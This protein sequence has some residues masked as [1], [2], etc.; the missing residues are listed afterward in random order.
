MGVPLLLS[1]SSLIDRVKYSLSLWCDGTFHFV[2]QV[3]NDLQFELMSVVAKNF[4]SK[5]TYTM[6]R[7]L[8]AWKTITS[9]ELLF[10]MF[11]KHLLAKDLKYSFVCA[12]QKRITLISYFKTILKMA[13]AETLKGFFIQIHIWKFF[14]G[15]TSRRTASAVMCT[16]KILENV[17]C[18][19]KEQY[20]R[21]FSNRF[22][23]DVV[24]AEN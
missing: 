24:D 21:S 7:L 2:F 10:K 8:T 16:E 11:L 17:L 18:S 19:C 12:V 9:R 15:D 6:A 1:C 13:F 5:R 20:L 3:S 14:Q 22:K 4:I 23:K